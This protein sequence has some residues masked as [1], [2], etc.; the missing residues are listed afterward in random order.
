[1]S[2]CSENK[3]GTAKAMP[4]TDSCY[5]LAAI[6]SPLLSSPRTLFPLLVHHAPCHPAL[7]TKTAQPK[8]CR[9]PIPV[10]C[11]LL[12]ARLFSPVLEL[13]SHYSSTTRHVI[14][15]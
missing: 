5:L 7:K 9:P 14:L 11:S 1:M 12:S 2:S 4:P 6:C 8:P 13:F 3:N 15:L 10:I